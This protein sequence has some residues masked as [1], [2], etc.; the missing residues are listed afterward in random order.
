MGRF[1]TIWEE[2]VNWMGESGDQGPEINQSSVSADRKILT[3]RRKDAKN[4]KKKA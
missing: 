2:V 4:Y 3:Q 1:I